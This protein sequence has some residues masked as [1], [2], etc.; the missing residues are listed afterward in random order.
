VFQLFKNLFAQA[1]PHHISKAIKE[2][3]FLVD[4]R[5][6]AEFPAGSVK[7]AVN[8]PLDKILSQISKFKTRNASLSFAEAAVVVDRQKV[9][10]KATAFSMSSTAERGNV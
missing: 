6:P 9:F 10:W 5:T 7:G 3:S 4:V 8:I 1:I 2:G